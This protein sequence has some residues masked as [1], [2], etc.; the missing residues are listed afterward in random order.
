MV[1]VGGGDGGAVTLVVEEAAV[2]MTSGGGGRGC[3]D[4]VCCS[5]SGLGEVGKCVAGGLAGRVGVGLCTR[6]CVLGI[7]PVRKTPA[8]SFKLCF[9]R[10]SPVPPCSCNSEPAFVQ[11]TRQSPALHAP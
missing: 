9:W 8:F 2:V 5:G 1:V 7:R 6:K 11:M 10:P 4:G 3:G